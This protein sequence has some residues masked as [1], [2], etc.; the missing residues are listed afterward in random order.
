MFC[1][2]PFENLLVQ[3]PHW[4][5]SLGFPS[6][7]SLAFNCHGSEGWWRQQ[8]LCGRASAHTSHIRRGQNGAGDLLGNG[9]ILFADEKPCGIVSR[10]QKSFSHLLVVGRGVGKGSWC[11]EIQSGPFA[12]TI[13]EC[14]EKEPEYISNAK[15]LP[16]WASWA[17][18]NN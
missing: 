1:V 2:S 6:A 3:S 13:E 9:A 5:K 14:R 15:I 8:H 10:V 17:V 4:F 11:K 7:G 18:I 12:L 16:F